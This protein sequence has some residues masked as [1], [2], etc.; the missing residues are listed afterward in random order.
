MFK[1]TVNICIFKWVNKELLNLE[2][3]KLRNL[4]DSNK[5][6]IFFINKIDLRIITF[7]TKSK[8]I[9]LPL[10]FLEATYNLS[11]YLREKSN[12]LT[13]DLLCS[14]TIKPIFLSIIITSNIVS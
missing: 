10:L 9:K 2:Y 4:S 8:E 6:S 13:K 12:K 14:K 11:P 1:S 7:L 3:Y 5:N